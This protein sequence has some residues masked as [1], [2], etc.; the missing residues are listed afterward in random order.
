M[1]VRYDGYKLYQD[2]ESEEFSEDWSSY[3][4]AS[5]TTQK[6]KAKFTAL[7]K[8]HEAEFDLDTSGYWN[9]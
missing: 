3:Q 5:M 6:A 2:I 9:N 7:D 8:T 1:I 4:G